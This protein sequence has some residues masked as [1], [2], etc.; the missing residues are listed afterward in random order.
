MP[1]DRINQKRYRKTLLIAVC[2][3]A[4]VHLVLSWL[5]LMA[6]KKKPKKGTLLL[7]AIVLSL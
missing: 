2:F 5:T 7:V 6:L 4:A 1:V 3:F